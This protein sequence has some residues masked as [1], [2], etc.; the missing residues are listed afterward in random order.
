MM[1]HWNSQLAKVYKFTSP[2]LQQLLRINEMGKSRN[3]G[4]H[5]TQKATKNL[6]LYTISSVEDT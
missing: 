1:L 2:V 6:S 4:R 3:R 5:E